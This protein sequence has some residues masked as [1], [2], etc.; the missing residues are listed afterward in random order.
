MERLRQIASKKVVGIA[1]R[2][3]YR[4]VSREEK[5]N[6]W[7]AVLQC[8]LN[9]E[10]RFDKLS[11]SFPGVR[12]VIHCSEIM[13]GDLLI[14]DFHSGMNLGFLG[15]NLS[16]LQIRVLRHEGDVIIGLIVGVGVGDITNM[17]FV[18]KT[19]AFRNEIWYFVSHRFS[20]VGGHKRER[21]AD[22]VR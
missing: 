9:I 17:R 20:V 21:L 14:S 3:S 6:Y 12:K 10:K 16:P 19:G 11:E 4:A 2:V 15:G 18:G 7:S 5:H 13:T 22:R 1:E 8:Y